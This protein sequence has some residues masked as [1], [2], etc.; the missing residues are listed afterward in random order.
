MLSSEYELLYPPSLE[1]K[2]EE[3][4]TYFLNTNGDQVHCLRRDQRKNP[5]VLDYPFAQRK[6]YLD[7]RGICRGTQLRHVRSSSSGQSI[8]GA[9]S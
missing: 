1:Y 7:R 2:L 4:H 3:A 5:G 8:F 9:T 6:S